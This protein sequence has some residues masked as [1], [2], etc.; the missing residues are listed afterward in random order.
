MGS[1]IFRITEEQGVREID[2][3]LADYLVVTVIRN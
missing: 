3:I 2:N 1:D